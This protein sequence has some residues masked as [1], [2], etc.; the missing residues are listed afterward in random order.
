MSRISVFPSSPAP[1][2]AL[3][4]AQQLTA[5]DTRHTRFEEDVTV[6]EAEGTSG[7]LK[8]R[9]YDQSKRVP[10]CQTCQVLP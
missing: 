5:P 1:I 7:W 3:L 9:L 2:V 8:L 6:P 10:T 4:L